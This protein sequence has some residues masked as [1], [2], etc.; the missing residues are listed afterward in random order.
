M[1]CKPI[2]T[3]PSKKQVRKTQS[4]VRKSNNLL[5][6]KLVYNGLSEIQTDFRLTCYDQT[7]VKTT[8]FKDVNQLLSVVDADLVNWIHVSGLKDV[9]GVGKLCRHFG[10]EVPAIQDILNVAHLA[11][12]EDVGHLLLV[13]LDAYSCEEEM[14]LEHQHVSLVLGKHFVLSFEEESSNRYNLVLKA[15]E[16]NLGQ[17]RMQK[18]DYLFNLLISMVVDSYLEVLEIQQEGLMDLEDLLIEFQM[19]PKVAGKKIQIYRKDLTRLKKSIYPLRE[20]FGHLLLIESNLIDK[21]C[22]VYL[23]DTNDH[24]Q[25]VF[26]MM[27]VNRETIASLV[28][29]YLANNDLHMNQIMKQLTVVSTIFIP[30]TFM[31]GVWGMN[32]SRMPELEWKYGYLAAWILL[33]VIGLLF[34][35]WLRRK[36]MF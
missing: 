22:L 17:V 23:R 12:V 20:H 18:A 14:V 19:V 31:V 13:I 27:D 15:L 33:F 35:V 5:Y 7:S 34:F 28:D 16:T 32:F 24:L 1:V 26:M 10:L 4:S 21:S 6:D 36:K 8:H 25:Q 11:K 29:L 30:L 9:D 3:V 2:R